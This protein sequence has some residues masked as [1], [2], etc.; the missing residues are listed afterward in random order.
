MG[1]D[2]DASGNPSIRSWTV[3]P[4][5]SLTIAAPWTSDD[6]NGKKFPG[7]Q[8]VAFTHWKGDS[9]ASTGVWQY[10]SDVS[11]DALTKFIDTYPYTDAPEATVQ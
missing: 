6:E 3:A 10:C 1:G 9:S 11:G 2:P 4:A 5:A 8:H 7:G